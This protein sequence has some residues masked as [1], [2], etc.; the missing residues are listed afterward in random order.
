MRIVLLVF[1]LPV[2]VAAAKGILM[3][4]GT[5]FWKAQAMVWEAW[6]VCAWSRRQT[7]QVIL[8]AMTAPIVGDSDVLPLALY[9]VIVGQW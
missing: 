3:D 9:H 6:C 1:F 4:A 7:S 5:H 2:T 8:C